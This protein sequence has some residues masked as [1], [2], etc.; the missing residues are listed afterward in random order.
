MLREW[1][2]IFVIFIYKNQQKNDSSSWCDNGALSLWYDVFF[3]F[4]FF[5]LVFLYI[6]NYYYPC[7][8]SL[9]L[10]QFF[11][12]VYRYDDDKFAHSSLSCPRHHNQ[13][14]HH[15]HH[16]RQNAYYTRLHNICYLFFCF[17]L[18][19]DMSWEKKSSGW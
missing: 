19:L 2:L 11:F 10:S 9:S 4:L 7:I 3:S 13:H 6:Q 15:H 1:F 14:H 17:T 5:C 8:W 12:F 18:F 16:D